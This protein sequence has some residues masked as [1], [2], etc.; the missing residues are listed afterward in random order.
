MLIITKENA[1]DTILNS[2]AV[3]PSE[4]IKDSLNYF[5]M[6]Q[7]ELA[8]RLGMTPKYISNI[9]KRKSGISTETAIKLENVFGTP[10]SFWIAAQ[11]RYD[12]FQNRIEEERTILAEEINIFNAYNL[13]TL[14]NKLVKLG[15][16]SNE[17]NIVLKIKSLLSFFEISRLSL[18]DKIIDKQLHGMAYTPKQEINK[19]DFIAWLNCGRKKMRDASLEPF[20]MDKFKDSV[21]YIRDLSS[22]RLDEVWDIIAKKYASSGVFIVLTPCIGKSS[23]FGYTEWLNGT[24]IIHLSNR[25]SLDYAWHSLFH[26][27]YHV[28]QNK[29][30]KVFID[31]VG[32]PTNSDDDDEKNA[33]NF[34]SRILLKDEDVYNYFNKMDFKN[35]D[36]AVQTHMVKQ[37]AK[38]KNIIPAIVVS[39]LQRLG[40][41]G[42]KTHL[43]SFKKK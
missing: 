19:Y 39:R 18:L 17:N 23:V 34:A 15:F 16:L 7:E 26:E 11:G 1:M 6:S 22:N 14:F 32:K 31:S 41:I 33:H 38:L 37:F 36:F 21:R 25:G 10:A 2:V 3:H 40:I 20:D 4:F 13:N 12:E 27:S 42:Y 30:L 8:S 5:K 9:M 35:F 43:N 29:R 24:P 28:I